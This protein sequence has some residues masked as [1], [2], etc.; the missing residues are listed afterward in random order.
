MHPVV[1]FDLAA[2]LM[3]LYMLARHGRAATGL[4]RPGRDGP[5]RARALVPFL[6]CLVALVVLAAAAR[7]LY[8]AASPAPGAPP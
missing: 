5:G 4:L 3:A 7:G 6:T 1:G 8:L 2:A